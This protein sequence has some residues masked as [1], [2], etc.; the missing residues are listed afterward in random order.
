MR[1]HSKRHTSEIDGINERTCGHCLKKFPRTPEHFHSN[2]VNSYGLSTVCK[3]CSNLYRTIQYR[4]KAYHHIPRRCKTCDSF[5]YTT[6]AHLNKG[7]RRNNKNWG[8]FCSIFCARHC[9]DVNIGTGMKGKSWNGRRRGENN[10]ANKYSVELIKEIK[11][12]IK[13]GERNRDIAEKFKM[14]PSYISNIRRNR[15]WAHV[16]I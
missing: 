7:K 8:S 15:I 10:P 11:I 2:L 6:R 9:P 13:T 4:K 1:L 3:A 16:T 12:L 5:F 14:H